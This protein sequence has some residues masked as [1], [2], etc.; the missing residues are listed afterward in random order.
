MPTSEPELVE[1][2]AAANACDD[3]A[4]A[5]FCDNAADDK[6]ADA[7]APTDAAAADRPSASLRGVACDAGGAVGAAPNDFA[8][9]MLVGV[10]EFGF[11]VID[12]L[13][14]AQIDNANTVVKA[15][16]LPELIPTEQSK[17]PSPG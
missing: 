15:Y 5:S 6:L 12:K 17:S 3:T 8:D 1:L 13:E 7:D 2:A 11:T 14:C 10:V 4:A 16:R 9:E